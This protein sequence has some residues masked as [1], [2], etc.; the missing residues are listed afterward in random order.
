M[1]RSFLRRWLPA[2]SVTAALLV[3][4]RVADAHDFWLVPDA[5]HIADGATFEVR[6][7][8]SSRFPT[9][10]SAVAPRRVAEA[11]V[12]SGWDDVRV[13][14]VSTAG[15]SLMLRHRPSGAGQRIVA[16]SL[17]PTTLRAFGP[18]FKRY[19][20]LEGAADLAAR[21]ER[22][23]ILPKTDSITRRYA[24]Y[25]KTLVQVGAAGPRAFS[26][27]VGHP[28]EFVPLRDPGSLRAGDT[29]PVRLLYNGQ[30]LADMHVHAGVS[31]DSAAPK[32]LSLATDAQGVARVPL[33]RAGLW[34]V[35]TLHIV[36]S[37]A[38]SG[39]D[40]DSHFVTLVFTVGA[41]HSTAPGNP[42]S[43]AV[44]DAVSR[45]H[46]A[47]ARSD[48]AAAL[49]LLSADAVILE[50]GGVETR[51]EYRS[52]HLPADIV[53]ASAVPLVRV[54]TRVVVRGDLAWVASSSTSQ[55]E[56]RGRQINSAGAELM[57]LTR[58]PSGWRIATIHWSSRTRRPQ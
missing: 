55:G 47:L 9:S 16:V 38:G 4:V 43:A 26:R 44:V 35:R 15:T 30:P 12:L 57:V 34:N 17:V 23:G 14:D 48:S 58:T 8:T 22:Q 50:S 49:E 46:E 25:A 54:V 33:E 1:S 39:A 18:G 13:T 42:D 11:R 6:G 5:F 41:G 45:Y 21:Y 2:A 20:E 28:A 53:Y 52:H 7:Q 19:M 51:D 36:P 56:F 40:W 31:R 32:D 27:V 10:E 24:K 37:V 29:L 3:V